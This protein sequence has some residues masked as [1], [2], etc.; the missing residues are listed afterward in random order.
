MESGAVDPSTYKM[1]SQFNYWIDLFEA[2]YGDVVSF[3]NVLNDEKDSK[4]LLF[5]NK[6]LLELIKKSESESELTPEEIAIKKLKQMPDHMA[7]NI[8]DI[9]S[10]EQKMKLLGL[11]YTPPIVAKTNIN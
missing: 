1:Q 9:M 4:K 3:W 8:M 10:G 6:L 2:E 5:F 11:E 7:T